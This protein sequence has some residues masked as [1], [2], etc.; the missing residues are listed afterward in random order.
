MECALPLI[1]MNPTIGVRPD[2]IGGWLAAKSVKSASA[3][4]RAASGAGAARK[5]GKSGSSAASPTGPLTPGRATGARKAALPRMPRAQLATLTDGAPAGDGW[6]HELKFDGYRMLCRIDDGH[7]RLWTRNEKDWTDRFPSIVEAAES[8]RVSNAILDGEVVIQLPDGTTSFQALQNAIRDRS[9]GDLL[10]YAFDLLYLDGYDV[11]GA[12][13]LERKVLLR[14]II[15]DFGPIRFSDHVV[16]HGDQMFEQACRANLEGIISKRVDAPY[17]PGRGGDWLK[18]KCIREQEFVIT[19]YTDPSGSRPGLGALLLGVY[20]SDGLE[21]CGKVG[22][23]FSGAVL[24]DLKRRLSKLESART[25]MKNP[26]RGADARGVHWVVPKLVAQVAYTERTADGILRHPTYR[27]LREDKAPHQVKWENPSSVNKIA[28]SKDADNEVRDTPM[29]R[30]SGRKAPSSNATSKATSKAVSRSPKA[31]GSIE[32]EGVRLSSPD[33]VLYP[34]QGTTK[35]D[36]ADYYVAIQDW[37]IPHIVGRPLTLVR[38]PQGRSKQCF[39][40]KHM[41]E[42]DSPW[43]EKIRVKEEKAARDYGTI[44]SVQ[45]LLTMV[46]MGALELHTWNSRAD[47]LEKPDRFIIDLDP[48][49]GLAWDLVVNAARE[50]RALLAELGLESFAKTTGG[51]GFH[52]VVPI[53]RRTGWDEV[54]DFSRA[55]A[56]AIAAASPDR[57]TLNVA[58]SK[59]KGR[60]LLDYLRNTRGATA[61]EV[62]STRA[63]EGATVSAPVS[64]EEL[65]GG[66]KPADFNIYNLPV[67]LKKLK[68]KDPWKDYGAVRQ[69]LT[70]PMKKRLGMK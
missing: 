28:S 37:I 57:Y 51:K 26:P 59:R 63:R 41:D 31:D 68:N 11:Q 20:G 62:F 33:K 55:V 7:A 64:W 54:R 53:E 12:P 69:S 42:L 14:S 43:V 38:C 67:R 24:T 39:F 29:R 1:F 46:Q 3:R 32:I 2:N 36:L 47:K 16:G 56:A 50:V 60:L 52:V 30:T 25:T 65:E 48:D 6:L 8:L 5:A 13:L 49:E 58:K 61:V 45:G 17:R 10:Y 19:G 40:Q 44:D 18:V 21:F 23:G 22:T 27:G 4:S 15:G 35:R 70:A 66:V 34:E 9:R